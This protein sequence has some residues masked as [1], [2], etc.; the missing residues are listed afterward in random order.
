MNMKLFLLSQMASKFADLIVIFKRAPSSSCQCPFPLNCE[1][2]DVVDSL[3][4]ENFETTYYT[5][6][7]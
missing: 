1:V 7:F 2:V 6:S 4:Q 5:F 3:V